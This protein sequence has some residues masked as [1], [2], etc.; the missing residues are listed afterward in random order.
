MADWGNVLLSWALF[1]QV[2]LNKENKMF[3]LLLILLLICT[4]TF[5]QTV[6]FNGTSGNGTVGSGTIGRE[7]VYTGT[8]AI[9]SGIITDTGT[10]VGIS[11]TAPG[12]AL[13]VQGTVRLLNGNVGVGTTLP[14]ATLDV[15][16]TTFMHNGIV[17]ITP[18]TSV[19]HNGFAAQALNVSGSSSAINTVRWGPAYG[20]SST[21]Q[22]ILGYNVGSTEVSIGAENSDL[23]LGASNS[24]LN[25]TEIVLLQG[26]TGFTGIN[27]QT[28]EAYLDAAGSVR[29]Q[30]VR[31]QTGV[32]VTNSGATL[33]IS[34]T[35]MAKNSIIQETGTTA[36][37]FT[38]DTGTN[39]STAVPNVAVGDM[40]E[41]SV[42]NASN[43]TI[44]MA[45]ASGTVLA[46]V[47]TVAT[48]QSRTFHAINTGSNSW[49]IY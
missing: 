14:L 31:V 6:S 43:Q 46:N 12:N 27:Q 10:N 29:L 33:T 40:V 39:L 41:F 48:L 44:T 25:F 2:V 45:G 22:G 3:K 19:A 37:T 11:S 15:N 20:G 5:A 42:S 24:G 23:Q 28:P 49:V 26:A 36:A 13:D 4:P 35:N 38:L 47:M 1:A 16:G 8:T 9:G 32:V 34:G 7:A 21:V 17:D 18:S 30:N